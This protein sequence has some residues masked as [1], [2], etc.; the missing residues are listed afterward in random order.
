MYP[1]LMGT[2]IDAD[3]LREFGIDACS[4]FDS[5]LSGDIDVDFE[6]EEGFLARFAS[7]IPNLSKESKTFEILND[8]EIFDFQTSM[9][10]RIELNTRI[11]IWAQSKDA[12]KGVNYPE[13]MLPSNVTKFLEENGESEEEKQKEQLLTMY[14]FIEE[15]KQEGFTETE[16][17]ELYNDY[18][19]ES[20]G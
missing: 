9:L 4:L 15:K 17:I 13:I 2:S 19:E 12:E 5:I 16:A 11:L 10:S 20:G 7:L 3:F 6:I 18:I 14:G 8:G 1:K